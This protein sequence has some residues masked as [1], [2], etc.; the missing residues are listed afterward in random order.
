MTRHS[1]IE[2]LQ[3]QIRLQESNY[4]YAV[5]SRKGINIQIYLKEH[6]KKLKEDLFRLQNPWLSVCMNNVALIGEEAWRNN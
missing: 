6:I 4:K 2:L 3:Q 1:K 5:E